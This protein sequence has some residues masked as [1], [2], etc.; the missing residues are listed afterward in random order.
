MRVEKGM[1]AKGFK[2]ESREGLGYHLYMERYNGVEGVIYEVCNKY[3]RI[4]F[5]EDE[6]YY[7]IEEAHKALLS[8]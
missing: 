8:V 6:W 2:F 1:K 4:V 5:S 7:P 3:I